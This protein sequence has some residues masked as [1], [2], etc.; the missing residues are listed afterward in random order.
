MKPFRA[1]RIFAVLALSS[2]VL[3][4]QVAREV[5]PGHTMAR[6]RNIGSLL[7][8]KPAPLPT[9]ALLNRSLRGLHRAQSPANSLVF[10]GITPCRVLDTRAGQGFSGPFGP[11]T[12]AG[13]TFPIQSSTKCTIPSIAPA[14]SC[15]VTAVPPGFFGFL[16]VYPTGATRPNASTLNDSTGLVLANATIVAA[17]TSGSV[18]VFATTQLT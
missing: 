12:L 8:P 10:M 6:G 9:G 11:P 5:A 14:Y 15:Y 17:G 3:T 13:R 7:R 1:G 18:D 2:N 16:T 4:S